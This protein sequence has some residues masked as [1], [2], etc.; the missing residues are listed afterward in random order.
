MEVNDDIKLDILF[1]RYLNKSSTS[2]RKNY[3]EE[4][5]AAESRY[6]VHHELQLYTQSHLITSDVPPDI[7]VA[8][9]TSS[10][11]TGQP[12]AG[13]YYGKTSVAVKIL[14]K[15]VKLGLVTVPSPCGRAYVAPKCITMS[16]PVN[17]STGETIV[18]NASGAR[19]IVVGVQNSYVF[20]KFFCGVQIDFAALETVSGRTSTLSGTVL[21]TSKQC[22]LSRVLRDVIPFDY[23]NGGY[24]YRLYRSDGSPIHFG[25][26][27]WLLDTYSGVLTFYGNLPAGVT[28]ATPPNITFYRYVG[29]IGLNTSHTKDGFVGIGTDS[30]EV[31]LDVDTTDAIGFPSGTTAQRPDPA[32]AGYTR[33]NTDLHTLEV[34]DCCQWQAL[35]KGVGPG[36]A[37]VNIATGGVRQTTI[38][39]MTGTSGVLVQSG[40]SDIGLQ[41]G[42]GVSVS[43]NSN[44]NLTTRSPN[45]QIYIGSGID[46]ESVV[47]NASGSASSIT[48]LGPVNLQGVTQ[49]SVAPGGAYYYNEP[50]NDGDWRAIEI[51]DPKDPT[52]TNLHFQKRINGVYVTRFKMD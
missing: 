34:F 48:L 11:D 39:N 43:A 31:S 40:S 19:A 7:Q 44:I 18:G 38:G 4:R 12:L 32:E 17:F 33:W 47:I 30:P 1:K 8:G 36:T 45:S 29:K 25:E 14:R 2:V 16:S 41:S 6:P 13:S 24:S 37:D 35:D 10:D 28:D 20:Y 23:G 15:Y 26:G 52:T 49:V 42:A 3:F 46:H 22:P 21:Q 51:R 27:N 5:E 50:Q 9:D